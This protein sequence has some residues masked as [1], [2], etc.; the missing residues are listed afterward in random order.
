MFKPF[1]KNNLSAFLNFLQSKYEMYTGRIDVRSYPYYVTLEP[2]DVCQLRC[3]T[4][5]TGIENEAKR[6]GKKFI[7]R[8]QRTKLGL[9]L[10]DAL[11]EEMGEYLFHLTLFNWG[12]PLINR[13][14]PEIIRRAKALE[15][16]TEINT[17]LSLHLSDEYIEDL[18]S[19][20]LDYLY[21]SIDGFSQEVYEIH[22]VGG[23]MELIK[24]N[25]ERFA[26]TRDR[27]GLDTDISYNFLVF[28]HN[29][30]EVS[31][32]ESYCKEVGIRFMRRE[33]NVHDPKWL[34]SYRKQEAPI[35]L[36]NE[37]PVELSS[38]MGERPREVWWALP[39]GRSVPSRCSW[40]YGYTCIS[41]GGNVVPCCVVMTEKHDV[42]TFEP[43]QAPFAAIWNNDIVKS[44]RAS[45]SEQQADGFEKAEHICTACPLPPF[46]HH[47]YSY[48]DYKVVARFNQLF[49]DTEPLLKQA[50]ELFSQNR[51]GASVDELTKSPIPEHPFG[52]ETPQGIA[53]F[54]NFVQE[55]LESRL[56]SSGLSR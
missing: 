44:G 45:F 47:M 22:R 4:C 7:V 13:N 19:A 12:E 49:G 31:A 8:R 52:V 41:S 3:P 2:S 9:D 11:L 34:P 37:T 16:Q 43:G 24:K 15:I 1:Q 30:H 56:A 17:N 28:S 23:N 6:A 27:L 36:W 55:N 25:L 38:D 40:H 20:G 18:L 51:Y 54:V 48:H 29:E 14:L 32:A 53:E 42:G 35:P 26:S 10:Y 21:A 50:F 46:I 5:A 33:A 39:E